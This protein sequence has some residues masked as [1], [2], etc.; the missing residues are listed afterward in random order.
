M[1]TVEDKVSKHKRKKAENYLS[2]LINHV[3][4]EIKE[5]LKELKKYPSIVKAVYLGDEKA[6]DL[7]LDAGDSINVQI[8][9]GTTPLIMAVERGHVHLIKKFLEAGADPT[10]LRKHRNTLL[11]LAAD[12]GWEAGVTSMFSRHDIN[13]NHQNLNG[14]TALMIATA[15]GHMQIVEILL[16]RGANLLLE[17]QKG[18]TALCYA[19][20][21]Q[22]PEIACCLY[23][24]MDYSFKNTF[25]K[26]RIELLTCPAAT[27]SFLKDMLFPVL[28]HIR[29]KMKKGFTLLHT[30]GIF[31]NLVEC[32][33]RNVKDADLLWTLFHLSA[34]LIYDKA[35]Y[36]KYIVEE[37]V[38]DFVEANAPELILKVAKIYKEEDQFQLRCAALLP[39]QAVAEVEAGRKWLEKNFTFLTPYITE[40]STHLCILNYWQE[41]EQV[42]VSV[43]WERFKDTYQKICVKSGDLITNLMIAKGSKTEKT[44]NQK[45]KK[46]RT[47]LFVNSNRYVKLKESE[48]NEE[49]GTIY[50]PLTKRNLDPCTRTRESKGDNFELAVRKKKGK[51]PPERKNKSSTSKTDKNKNG[52]KSVNTCSQKHGSRIKEDD[53]SLNINYWEGPRNQFIESES[54]RSGGCKRHPG[55]YASA[56]KKN[57]NK[58]IDLELDEY[59]KDFPSILLSSGCHKPLDKPLEKLDGTRGDFISTRIFTNASNVAND[60]SCHL[61]DLHKDTSSP[62]LEAASITFS[63][64][65]SSNCHFTE[66][67]ADP[68]GGSE[69]SADRVAITTNDDTEDP[70]SERFVQL[71]SEVLTNLMRMLMRKC[72]NSLDTGINVASKSGEEIFAEWR[73]QSQRW[74]PLLCKLLAEPE[75]QRCFVKS[76]F[77]VER[78][79]WTLRQGKT[80]TYLGFYNNREEV[81]IKKIYSNTSCKTTAQN[82]LRLTSNVIHHKN[83]LPILE[84]CYN[85]SCGPVYTITKLCEYSLQEYLPLVQTNNLLP[86][87]G[88]KLVHQL[89]EG[90]EYLH[91]QSILH[92]RLKPNNVQIGMNGN[93]LLSD[94]GLLDVWPPLCGILTYSSPNEVS[95]Y[96]WRCQECVTAISTSVAKSA[97]T[98]ASDIQVAGML[99]YFI[100]TGLHPFGSNDIECQVKI[101][102][103]NPIFRY[104]GPELNDLVAWIISYEPTTRPTAC[105]VLNHPYFW[106]SQKKLDF[107]IAVA[108][109]PEMD[110]K[111]WKEIEGRTEFTRFENWIS[112]DTYSGQH[113]EKTSNLLR[114]ISNCVKP[115]NL[116]SDE[117]RTIL[118]NPASYFTENFPSLVINIY[119]VL[120]RSD[121]K[122]RPS[123]SF[124]F[125]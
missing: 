17:D 18:A 45:I 69:T 10:V 54:S 26:R 39:I 25:V 84:V 44:N 35:D 72:R 116:L 50:D 16:C 112:Q 79:E 30:N 66:D 3:S 4:P 113:F 42:K 100:F 83:I 85:Y 31:A 61:W 43:I 28:L 20:F 115:H 60:S 63:D 24:K 121:W 2:N 68:E 23:Q 122:Y 41:E 64:L 81:V 76:A 99:T 38:E 8:A 32:A 70:E 73:P 14:K 40:F 52:A 75:N 123:L 51:S 62:N 111:C 117:V 21:H 101:G 92:G 12:K 56:V 36:S 19:V 1:S 109:Q 91:S 80:S 37:L 47:K 104:L 82:M 93:L 87:V 74:K 48:K 22:H 49:T 46:M 77:Y 9:D 5:N 108:N 71:L 110:S 98:A 13:I 125:N 114:L 55:T 15:Q 89:F 102:E 95:V 33:E 86:I 120:R 96:S 57:L 29:R 59:S 103:G 34:C 107:L 58:S 106:C 67:R 119:K 88:K 90:L 65:P 27:S 78:K 53:W 7:L 105:M 118:N 6:I 124:V 97:F 11:V 94:F